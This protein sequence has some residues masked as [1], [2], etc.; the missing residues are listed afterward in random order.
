[1]SD[2]RKEPLL[3]E[4]IRAVRWGQ[5]AN[6]SSIGSVIDTLFVGSLIGGALFAAVAAAVAREAPRTVGKAAEPGDAES[7]PKQAEEP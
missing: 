1:M 6:C 5:G 2:K 3:A 4:H 7:P